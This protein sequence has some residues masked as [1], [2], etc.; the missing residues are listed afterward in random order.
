MKPNALPKT[1]L[2][3]WLNDVH[4][5]LHTHTIPATTKNITTAHINKIKL[6]SNI[7]KL[8]INFDCSNNPY[9]FCS[10]QYLFEDRKNYGKNSS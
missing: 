10:F 6:T 8:S 1:T 2:E 4:V 3:S 9:Q 7:N 5:K